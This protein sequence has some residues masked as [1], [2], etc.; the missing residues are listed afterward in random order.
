MSAPVA[1]LLL[2]LGAISETL[3][4]LDIAVCVFDEQDRTLLWNRAFLRLFP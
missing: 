3:D 4:G 2:L 1:E